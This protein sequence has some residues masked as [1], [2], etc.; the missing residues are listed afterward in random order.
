VQQQLHDA[1][2]SSKRERN[3]N[4]STYERERLPGKTRVCARVI[5]EQERQSEGLMQRFIRDTNNVHRRLPSI[6]HSASSRVIRE[7][8]ISS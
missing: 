1:F 4:E 2:E 6:P 5:T 8:H 3:R 7:D